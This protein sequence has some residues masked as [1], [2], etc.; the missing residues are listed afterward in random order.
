[1]RVYPALLINFVVLPAVYIPVFVLL[2]ISVAL[3]V[4]LGLASFAFVWLLHVLEP[5]T[6]REPGWSALPHPFFVCLALTICCPF[7]VLVC[8][9]ECPCF[10]RKN[11][12]KLLGLLF[13]LALIVVLIIAI[14]GLSENKLMLSESGSI[15]VLSVAASITGGSLAGSLGLLSK[16]EH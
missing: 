3:P 7:L 16:S 13:S 14:F 8:M 10:T 9:C 12:A 6:H 2:H 5:H 1:M 15:A 4:F 11:G